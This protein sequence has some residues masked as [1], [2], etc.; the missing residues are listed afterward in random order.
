VRDSRK[1]IG[2]VTV[3]LLVFLATGAARPDEFFQPYN[4]QN[5]IRWTAL[6]GIL[7]IGVV[8]PILT[9][10]IDLSIGSVVGLV[11]ALLPW[12]LV[13]AGFGVAPALLIVVVVS[14]AIGAF[15]GLLVTRLHL[16]PFVVTLCG[17]LLYRGLARW[18]TDDQT[19]GFGTGYQGLRTL[20]TGKPVSMAL[21]L[22]AVGLGTVL[23]ASLSLVRRRRSDEALAGAPALLAFGVLLVLG[24]ALLAV[25]V[26]GAVSTLRVPTPF[27]LLFLLAVSA[28]VF[29]TRT[30]PGRH[31]FAVGRNEEAARYAGVRTGRVVVGAYVLC[32][33][34]AG[35]GA[36]L[37][38][39]DVN[40]IQPAAHG[41]FYEL[42]AIA[43]AVLGGCS[44]R[45]GEGSI[46][47]VVVGAA[48]VRVLY[49]SIN[50]LSISPTLELVIIGG[51]LLVGVA[52]DELVGRRLGRR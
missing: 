52:A 47:G 21:F 40:A 11:G 24:G 1:L 38:A 12:L 44:L 36:V 45:G 30:V 23:A 17:L 33:L 22:P 51:A 3:F 14:L 6:Y 18:L 10:G 31:L 2:I 34:C 20:A 9:G 37:F 42:Y 4:L 39:L 19:Q 13:E 35:L 7:S 26:A 32:S 50:L 27:L 46:A 16:Q 28:H 5:L 43:A 41:S 48:L 29:L 8:F 15:H 25:E 49:N